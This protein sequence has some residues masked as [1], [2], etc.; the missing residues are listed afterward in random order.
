MAE[1]GRFKI[2]HA[3]LKH[4]DAKFITAAFDSSLPF[5]A[6]IGSGAQWGE[7]PFSEVDGFLAKQEQTIHD[8][9]HYRL[10]GEGNSCHV[11][12]AEVEC[13]ADGERKVVR[14]GTAH[15]RANDWPS[16]VSTQEH[17]EDVISEAKNFTFLVFLVS[18]FTTGDLRKGA[19]AALIQHVKAIAEEE[20]RSV[21]FVDCWA[22]ND[23]KLV[24]YYEA[25]GFKKIGNFSVVRPNKDPWPGALFR[26]DLGSAVN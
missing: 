24:Q 3:E 16:Y 20:G 1:I 9:N 4:R 15:A 13:E 21:V 7:Q 18:D 11:W 12:I 2:R 5:Q 26:M 6:S 10:T 25:Q 14:V 17:L 8:A 23:G 19:G 22:G